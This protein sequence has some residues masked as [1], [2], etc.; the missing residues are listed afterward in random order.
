MNADTSSCLEHVQ[1]P[2]LV[3]GERLSSGMFVRSLKANEVTKRFERDVDPAEFGYRL[4][5]H[6]WR[7]EPEEDDE[8]DGLSVNLEACTASLRCALLLHPMPQDFVHAAIIDI[9]E[10]ATALEIGIA[11]I[12]DPDPDGFA[13]PCH[14]NLLPTDSRV[15]DL[16]IAL[17]RWQE[18]LFKPNRKTPRDADAIEKA[19]REHGA[20][21]RV[22]RVSLDVVASSPHRSEDMPPPGSRAEVY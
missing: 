20:Y 1:V 17:K 15:Q 11:A 7:W 16:I 12:Y 5:P 9:A 14:F 2:P 13:N 10:L 18:K 19:R 21:A 3:R 8:C 6:E 22:F 4:R